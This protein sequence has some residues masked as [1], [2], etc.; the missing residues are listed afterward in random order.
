MILADTKSCRDTS[1][2]LKTHLLM[3]TSYVLLS[4]DVTGNIYGKIPACLCRTDV[5]SGCSR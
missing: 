3:F 4:Q 1:S 2:L 5:G